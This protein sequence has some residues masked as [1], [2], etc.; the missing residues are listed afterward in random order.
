LGA[1]TTS[2]P[3]TITV[4]APNNQPPSVYI[5]SSTTNIILTAPG[6]ISLNA[7]ASDADGS[8]SKVEFFN[9]TTLVSTDLTAPYDVA[10]SNLA[11]GT[12]SITAKATD[13]LGAS[14]T[15]GVITITVNP[16][17]NTCSGIAQYVENGGYAPGAKVKNSGT[18]YEC[19]PWPYSGWCN[20]A[21]WAYAPGTGLYWQD[22]WI[23]LGACAARSADH[24]AINESALS[25]A[26]NPFTAMTTI[27]IIVQEAGPVSV[28]VYDK[29][30]QLIIVLADGY[31]SSGSHAL[32]LD[33]SN[34][35]SDLYIVKYESNNQV[36]TRKVMKGQ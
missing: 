27:D 33:G 9:G 7:Q 5:S 30:G 13:N 36:I 3:I 15:S 17:N 32:V 2:S 4:N 22:A 18:R 35:A 24:G 16:A 23:A 1:H 21:A 19:K 10:F 20:G 6:N 11:V 31:M 34:L 8:I 12:Y 25:N 14:T 29:T 26:P 28:K